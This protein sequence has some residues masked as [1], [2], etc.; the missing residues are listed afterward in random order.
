MPLAS[1][2]VNETD[3]LVRVRDGHIVAIGGL[4]QLESDRE[5]LG[6]SRQRGG[7][8]LAGIFGNKA[9]HGR[10]KEVVVLIKPSII[11]TAQDWEAQTQRARAALEDIDAAR[12]RVICLDGSA[13]DGRARTPVK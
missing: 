3:T 5:F 6:S 8:V 9:N 10:K 2:N 7:P 4:M 13:Q 12:A 1:S 11:R